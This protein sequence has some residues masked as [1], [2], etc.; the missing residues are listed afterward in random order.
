MKYALKTRGKLSKMDK[1]TRNFL[2]KWLY[3]HVHHSENSRLYSKA[4]QGELS[5]LWR[6]R[7]GMYR[8]IVRIQDE[9][10][11]VLTIDIGLRASIYKRK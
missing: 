9:A 3:H 8:A 11:V 10:Q 5:H 7:I 1:L 6:Y 4:L 2:L